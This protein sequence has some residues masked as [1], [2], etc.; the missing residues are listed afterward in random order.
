MM[1]N[2]NAVGEYKMPPCQAA[3]YPTAETMKNTPSVMEGVASY[4]YMNPIQQQKQPAQS[5]Q[6]FPAASLPQTGMQQPQTGM[7]QSVTGTGTGQQTGAAMP[8][9]PSP[10]SDIGIMRQSGNGVPQTAGGQAPTTSA[11]QVQTGMP[12]SV[13]TPDSLQYLNGFLRTQIGRPVLVTFLV[14]TNTLTDRTGT[15][16]GVGINYILIR[17]TRTDD[18]LACDFYNIKF[19]RF[20]Y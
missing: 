13:V 8:Q 19:I 20:Y 16:L 11:T 14:G 15:L 18:I 4:N 3:L 12:P 9:M 7:L 6:Q 10:Q 2:N 17:E 1:D 5:T